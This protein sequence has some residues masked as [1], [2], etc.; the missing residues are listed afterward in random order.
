MVWIQV[1]YRSVASCATNETRVTLP[2]QIDECDMSAK[3][4]LIINVRFLYTQ[5]ADSGYASE[6]GLRRHGSMLSIT[7][8]TSL[9]TASASSFKVKWWLLFFGLPTEYNM[10][11]PKLYSLSKM[12]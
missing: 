7:S 9:S 10:L 5:Q 4:F 11:E 3:T 2:K 12:W 8:A 1:L 6:N